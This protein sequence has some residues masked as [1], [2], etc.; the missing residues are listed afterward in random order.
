MSSNPYLL[1]RNLPPSMQATELILVPCFSKSPVSDSY[2][3]V[4]HQNLFGDEDIASA[5]MHTNED[6]ES[7]GTI[8]LT[9]VK[10]VQTMLLCCLFLLLIMRAHGLGKSL[11]TAGFN[12]P[13]G[14]NS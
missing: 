7:L 2:L 3:F 10:P 6:G 11:T 8:Q 14:L 4:V 13:V 5:I 1:V 12:R 9:F